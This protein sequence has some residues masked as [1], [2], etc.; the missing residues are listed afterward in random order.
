MIFIKLQ[1]NEQHSVALRAFLCDMCFCKQ[2]SNQPF[3]ELHANYMYSQKT[4]TQHTIECT[5]IAF[6]DC[7]CYIIADLLHNRRD[8]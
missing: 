8:L 6:A 7:K 1:F 2:D 4:N 3:D 5:V